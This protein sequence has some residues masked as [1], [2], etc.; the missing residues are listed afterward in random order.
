MG[1]DASDFIHVGE[2]E[3]NV[4]SYEV[5]GRSGT[6]TYWDGSYRNRVIEAPSFLLSEGAVREIDKINEWLISSQG[7]DKLILSHDPEHFYLARAVRGI[8][9]NVR[10]DILTPFTVEFDALPQKYLKTGEREYAAGAKIYNPTKFTSF[11]IWKIRVN[12]TVQL[13]V[14]G[15]TAVIAGTSGDIILDTETGIATTAAGVNVN[16]KVSFTE[17]LVLMPGV[18][19]ISISGG[20]LRYIPRWWTI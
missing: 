11:P 16:A 18:N 7:Y 6:L 13:N 19:E 20:T 14:G 2:S 8:P 1:I 4:E 3:P 5:P 12:D 17:D 10:A 15:R 9:E